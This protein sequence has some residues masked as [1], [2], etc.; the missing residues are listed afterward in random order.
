MIT[1]LPVARLEGPDPSPPAG[2]NLDAVGWI[3]VGTVR[4]FES[5]PTGERTVQLRK[6]IV[7]VRKVRLVPPRALQLSLVQI[8]KN[9]EGIG[10][11]FV[12]YSFGL[13]SIDLFWSFE[14]DIF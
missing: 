7:W 12:N 2:R 4:A 1:P 11:E 10:K 3:L 13:V 6:P 8:L 14:L 5:C 9:E